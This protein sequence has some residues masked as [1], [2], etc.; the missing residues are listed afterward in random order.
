MVRYALLWG[1]S[2]RA[3]CRR[4]GEKEHYPDVLT[5]HS[6]LPFVI[7]KGYEVLTHSVRSEGKTF[8]L[9]RQS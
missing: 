2:S 9:N 5:L 7:G 6:A 1:R 8:E 4:R 3:A